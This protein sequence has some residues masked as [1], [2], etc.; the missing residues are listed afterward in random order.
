MI[1]QALPCKYFSIVTVLLYSEHVFICSIVCLGMFL[2]GGG[3]GDGEPGH[4]FLYMLWHMFNKHTSNCCFKD[5]KIET[6]SLYIWLLNS[7]GLRDFLPDVHSQVQRIQIWTL[8][9]T[10]RFVH[11]STFEIHLK[12][13]I[14]S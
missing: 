2:W 14:L 1:E 5:K 4:T 12:I 10:W 9:S 13:I 7:N 11:A 8:S 3:G 6:R